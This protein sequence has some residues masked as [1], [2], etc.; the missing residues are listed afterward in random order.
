MQLRKYQERTIKKFWKAFDGGSRRI[1]ITAPCGA[2]KTVM[3]MEIAR[4]AIEQGFKVAIY[5]NRQLL[6][7]QTSRVFSGNRLSHGVRAAGFSHD[8]GNDL[9]ICSVQTEYSRAVKREV[10]DVHDADL[11]IVD[12]AHQMKANSACQVFDKHTNA[13]ILGITATP[14]DIGHIY[15]KLIT[16]CKPSELRSLGYM[17]PCKTFAPEEPEI[18]KMALS[19]SEYSIS[20]INKATNYRALVGSVIKWY[21]T[22]NLYS[23]PT[24]LFAPGVQQSKWFVDQFQKAGITAA[25]V[26]GFEVY[27]GGNT[28]G[29]S[30]AARNDIINALREGEIQVLCNR[31][32]LR[33]AIDI[34]ELYHCILACPIGSPVSYL[35]SGG[36]L[37]RPSP[38][39]DH[40]ILQDHGGNCWTHGSLNEDRR[41]SLKNTEAGLA[42]KN[43]KAR[44]K[45]EA[46]PLI[47]PRCHMVRKH[48]LV[49]PHCG[50]E[51]ATRDRE[52]LQQDGTLRKI[53]E[54]EMMQARAIKERSPEE[55]AWWGVY[56]AIK[57]YSG[58]QSM[59]KIGRAYRQ[60]T[61]KWPGPHIPGVPKTERQWDMSVN[62]YNKKCKPY[63]KA[64][65]EK[66]DAFRKEFE[67]THGKKG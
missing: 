62:E 10:W 60:N 8:M 49:C 38:G 13:A 6:T 30:I 5:T 15:K 32:V 19:G 3:F 45:I 26:D 9:Q 63:Y 35:Q 61:G 7:S 18:D 52:V 41:W 31:F 4:Q 16:A 33:E 27:R 34:P 1:C 20:E 12:E 55:R 25:H 37:L 14:V 51:K 21:R 2:G 65:K 48:G 22:L 59:R 24:V 44:K 43:K 29:S 40:V 46:L 23:L 28:V 39:L 47:C 54:F 11:V 67:K 36:R 56:Y 58:D 53:T 64:I 17:L 42:K 66:A 50:M 57:R